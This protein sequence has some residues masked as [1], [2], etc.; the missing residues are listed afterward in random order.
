[1]RLTYMFVVCLSGHDSSQGGCP[2]ELADFVGY[3]VRLNELDKF[4]EVL[5]SLSEFVRFEG[6]LS[7]VVGFVFCSQFGRIIYFWLSL[8]VN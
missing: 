3:G 7:E 4:C 8:G 2:K 5:G 1:M 6:Y